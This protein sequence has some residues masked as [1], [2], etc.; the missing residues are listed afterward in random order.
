MDRV[1]KPNISESYTPL[2][3]SYSNYSWSYCI[4]VL[5]TFSFQFIFKHFCNICYFIGLYVLTTLVMNCTVLWILMFSSEIAQHFGGI[6]RLHL[7]GRRINEAASWAKISVI[8]VSVGLLL[9]IIFHPEDEGDRY[10]WNIGI[11]LNYRVL[12]SKRL[13]YS[14]LSQFIFHLNCW[15]RVMWLLAYVEDDAE[16]L[17]AT[18][19]PLKRAEWD[20]FTSELNIKEVATVSKIWVFNSRRSNRWIEFSQN[21]RT[22]GTCGICLRRVQNVYSE[23]VTCQ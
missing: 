2:S 11:S 16:M 13:Y 14:S 20:T 1:R 6:Y 19:V 3:E 4:V 9:S 21:P 17:L 10:L 15:L 8:T 22:A 23:A 5:W 12:Q 7:H 18:I